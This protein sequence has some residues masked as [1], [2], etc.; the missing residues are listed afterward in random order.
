MARARYLLLILCAATLLAGCA[1]TAL[2]SEREYLLVRAEKETW[3]LVADDDPLYE[4]FEAKVLSD[5]YLQLLLSTYEH[6]TEAIIGTRFE[7]PH[8]Q[9]VQSWPIIVLG[10]EQPGVLED[11]RVAYGDNM[12]NLDLALALGGD[13][14]IDL[15]AA[16]EHMAP[17]MASLLLALVGAPRAGVPP[18]ARPP[19]DEP[20]DPAVALERG[21]Q[22]ALAAQHA[23]DPTLLM[24]IDHASLT[25][26][27]ALRTPGLVGLFLYR[28][29]EAS[30]PYYPQHYMLWFVDYEP[31]EMALAQLVLAL[32]R[33]PHDDPVRGLIHTYTATYPSSRD[34]VHALA[35]DVFG[36]RPGAG[37]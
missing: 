15:Q 14:A 28:L 23:G 7:S 16:R 19:L 33:T 4:R 6:T 20:T 5:P 17:G 13:G 9:A 24:A 34:T 25:V 32:A 8:P 2:Q 30:E 1:T 22:L 37:L 18:T 3:I 35:A 10:N 29:L 31:E 12:V 11:I 21:L 36:I 27:E 26:E